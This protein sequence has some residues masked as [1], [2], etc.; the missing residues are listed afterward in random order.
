MERGDQKRLQSPALQFP[1]IGD[2][3]DLRHERTVQ[4]RLPDLKAARHAEAICVP[5]QHIAK[6]L[7]KLPATDIPEAEAVTCRDVARATRFLLGSE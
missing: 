5:E 7:S 2:F 1:P 3:Q 4:E 6:V